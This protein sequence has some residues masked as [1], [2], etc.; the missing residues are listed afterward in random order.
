MHSHEHLDLLFDTL[1]KGNVLIRGSFSDHV[2]R[3][4]F[5]HQSLCGLSKWPALV[6]TNED[7]RLKFCDS[8]FLQ[9]AY[10]I[11]S[12][13]SASYTFLENLNWLRGADE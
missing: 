7:E 2:F 9:M 1:W 4:I 3:L 12:N 10:V 11:M 5:F 13:D 8:E 6:E